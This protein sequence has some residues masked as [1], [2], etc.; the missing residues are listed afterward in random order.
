MQL[1]NSPAIRIMNLFPNQLRPVGCLALGIAL[2][3]VLTIFAATG[4]A[5][6]NWPQFRGADSRSVATNSGLPEHW[7]ATEN[8]AW[9][10][11]IP[12]RGW[13]S[14]V[15][16]GNQVFLTTV[17]NSGKSEE[18]KK[19]LYFGGDRPKYSRDIHQWKVVCLDLTTGDLLWERQ[20]HEGAPQSAIHLKSSYASETPVTD[21][22][23]V[24][25]YF[26]N[27][28]LFCFDLAGQLLWQ[29]L[30][31]PHQTR[32]SWGTAASP[33]LHE[34][35]L[36]LVND[37]EDDSYL[38]A[39]DAKT[40]DEVWRVSRQENSNWSTPFVWVNDQ[41]TEIVTPGT[42]F[43]RSYDLQGNLLWSLKGMSSI[44]IATPYE[45]N[46]LLY[47][48]SGYV[49]D[50][51]KPIFAVRPGGQG[52]ISLAAREQSNQFVAWRQPKAAP[53]NPSTLV[54]GNR[55]FVLY[56][57]GMLA[58]LNASDGQYIFGAA[59]IPNGRNFTSSPWAY[60]DKVF[61][62]NEDGVT[63]VFQA[64][65]EFKL[66]HSN[67]LEE[68]DMGMATPAIA[69]DRLLIRT[70]ARIYCIQQKK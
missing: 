49:L 12:G 41:R 9:K 7:S 39:C 69:G 20:V 10:R 29:K 33:V 43:T 16:W 51:K 40:G 38:L 6:T 65:D 4:Q 58:C 28:G 13:S 42:D 61:C 56:D 66:L 21:G 34:G 50:G 26:G 30:L 45:A 54:L 3:T 67:S 25:C 14:P 37:N 11:D 8:V 55:L 35:R 44:T 64:G 22:E 19:G 60:Q 15:V 48:S 1:P 23:R 18:P 53:Y 68:D 36:Y 32:N 24:Y 27:L 57:R 2:Q 46:G 70:A 62:L 63:F 31:P 17:I 59:R 52:D 5:Q 47:L